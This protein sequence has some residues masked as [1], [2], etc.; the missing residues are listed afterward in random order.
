[1][2]DKEEEEEVPAAAA[3]AA[4]K[5]KNKKKKKAGRHRPD[6]AYH[7]VERARRLRARTELPAA[8]R[9]ERKLRHPDGAHH[10]AAANLQGG[11]V[12]R[13]RLLSAVAIFSVGPRLGKT[14]C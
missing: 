10:P 7:R 3:E 6:E 13:R 8:V 1:M 14:T 12:A 9:C 4:K 5:K 2:G 11:G